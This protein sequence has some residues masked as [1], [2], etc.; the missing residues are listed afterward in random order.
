MAGEKII[1]Q[2]DRVVIQVPGSTAN[3]GPYFDKAGAALSRP[4]L[5]VTLE[6][7]NGRE[8]DLAPVISAASTP[9]G[10]QRGYAGV[11]ALEQY[12]HSLGVRQGFRLTYADTTKEGFPTGGT[13]L[14]GAESTG[15][16]TAVVVMLNQLLS[17]KEVVLAS[18]KGEP[19]EHK[20]NVTPSVLGGMV[21][22]SDDPYSDETL[23]AR[24]LPPK[25]L[26]L[27]M[28]FSS[29]QK[30]KGT[31]GTLSVL[32]GPVSS[33]DMVRQVGRAVVGALLLRDGNVEG[34]LNLV[35][36]DQYHE[37]RRADAGLYGGFSAQELFDFKGELYRK[38]RIA[39]AISGAGPNMGIWFNK[40]VY[41]KGLT[42]EPREY[43]RLWGEDHSLDLGRIKEVPISR[44]G[45]Y[46][47]ARRKYPQ[48]LLALQR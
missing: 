12:L 21:F 37:P 1:P 9:K 3:L 31:E 35:L 44:M 2:Y 41:P 25:H 7:I 24:V 43:I 42:E 33:K 32:E 48:S 6:P 27:A 10:R 30:E 13:G 39:L 16:I 14:S 17:P 36:G 38:Y 20:D 11:I 28:V 29:H 8:I 4:L 40:K 45:A 26:G 46:A 19:N 22:L 15:A 18:A 47:Y 23:I 34:F 5:Q